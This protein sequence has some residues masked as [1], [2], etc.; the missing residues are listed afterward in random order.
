MAI[1]VTMQVVPVDWNRFKAALDAGRS[2]PATGR[3]SS[4]VYRGESDS[5]QVLIVEEWDSHDSMHR[6]QDQVGGEFNRIAGTEGMDWQSGVWE[7][8]EE[9][10]P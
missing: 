7:L 10:K 2:V 4:L 6:Y 5:S 9:L 3:H 8:A 1:V